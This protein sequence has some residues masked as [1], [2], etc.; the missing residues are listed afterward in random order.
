MNG[1]Q[2][3][4]FYG[5]WANVMQ[6]FGVIVIVFSLFLFMVHYLLAFAGIIVG[7]GIIL[8]GKSKR[9]DYKMQ[10]G[11]IIHKGDW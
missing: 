2:N 6:Y 1:N 8:Y 9:F 7:I 5:L 10:S 3:L 11:N 4:F